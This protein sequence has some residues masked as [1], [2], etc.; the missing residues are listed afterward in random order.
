MEGLVRN[1]ALQEQQNLSEGLDSR[2]NPMN[3]KLAIGITLIVLGVLVAVSAV[4]LSFCFRMVLASIILGAASSVMFLP[5][6]IS[7]I[8]G[9]QKE[10][11]GALSTQ[12]DSVVLNNS[13]NQTESK[14]E[15]AVRRIAACYK[16]YKRKNAATK[17]IQCYKQYRKNMLYVDKETLPEIIKILDKWIVSSLNKY[18][19]IIKEKPK[20]KDI[21]YEIFYKHHLLC[22][23]LYTD[24]SCLVQYKEPNFRVLVYFDTNKTPQSIALYNLKDNDL[25]LI[26]TNSDNLVHPIN[27]NQK[28]GTGSEIIK[29]LVL[30]SEITGK[31]IQL[32]S[33]PLAVPFYKKHGF[34]KNGE[35]EDNGCLPMIYQPKNALSAPL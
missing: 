15:N 7:A 27:K 29:R 26:V 32:E 9:K 13:G 16:H 14:E 1:K 4:I 22:S 24:I 21:V 35:L 2:K 25:Y 19:T 28:R 3:Q 30:R 34:K 5:G 8:M 20:E 33:T 18:N 10:E 17:I 12:H 23:N 6:I 31:P 11:K